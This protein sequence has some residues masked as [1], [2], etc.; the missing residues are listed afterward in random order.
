M[1]GALGR[2]AW[3]NYLRFGPWPREAVVM[4][5]NTQACHSTLFR[6]AM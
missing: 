5:P 1:I 4:T 3:D 2:H 6:K